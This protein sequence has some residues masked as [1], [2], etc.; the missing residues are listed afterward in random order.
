MA[1]LVK[2]RSQ[3]R[4]NNRAAFSRSPQMLERWKRQTTWIIAHETVTKQSTCKRIT[5]HVLVQDRESPS[6][7]ERIIKNFGLL[8]R[9]MQWGSE[10]LSPWIQVLVRIQ[11]RVQARRVHMAMEDKIRWQ[12][13][14]Q[15]LELDAQIHITEKEDPCTRF[16]SIVWNRLPRKNIT[17]MQE[18][19]SRTRGR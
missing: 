12:K 10:Q 2:K 15:Q 6:R 5:E 8:S 3:L 1:F 7:F 16:L 11:T 13:V 19:L 17:K 18:R 4:G 9:A 14:E